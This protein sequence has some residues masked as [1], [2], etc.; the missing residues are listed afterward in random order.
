MRVMLTENRDKESGFVNGQ[1]AV[2]ISNRRNTVL[3]GLPNGDTLFT[4]PI[5]S[6]D[7]DGT[8]QVAYAF[9]PGYG[10][11][12]CKSQGA[13]LSKVFLWLDSPQVPLGTAYVGL[14]RVRRLDDIRFV[15]R[16]IYTQVQP[17]A[18]QDI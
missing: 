4:H 2:V 1:R 16:M 11:T 10:V 17:V 7:D 12:I 15:T 8:R 13:T 6:L 3:L 9:T 5:S 18:I 14:S